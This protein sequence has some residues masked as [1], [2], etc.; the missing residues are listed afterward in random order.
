MAPLGV[1]IRA[2]RPED[3]SAV[4]KVF[5]KHLAKGS[6]GSE[7][8]PDYPNHLLTLVVEKDGEI[9]AGGTGRLTGEL[10]L[11][12]DPGWG[13][14]RERWET[15]VE[16]LGK[17]RVLAK[18]A[19]IDEAHLFIPPGLRRYAERLKTLPNVFFDD[20]LHLILLAGD[21]GEAEAVHG[22]Q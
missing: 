13:S 16:L 14:P 20:R 3:R 12:Q 21:A 1:T 6:T 4:V 5:E 18:G 19:G 22:Q 11:F 8:D 10:F 2:Y 15:I 9:V 7:L 17:A